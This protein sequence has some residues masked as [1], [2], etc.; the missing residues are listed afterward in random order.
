MR[1]YVI[2]AFTETIF[3]GNPAAV[4]VLD[5]WLPEPL[6][7][8]IAIENNLSET[9]FT[10]REGNV[11]R[12]RWFT[13]GGEVDLCGHATLATAFAIVQ[14]VEP[15][16]ESIIF[17]T[18]S[19]ELRVVK[20]KD[21]YEMDFPSYAM[22]QVAVTDLMENVIGARPLEAWLGRDLVCILDNENSVMDAKPDL[23]RA[24][25][26]DGT[27]LHITARGKECDCVSRS[28]APKLNVPEDPVCGSGHCHIAPLWGAKLNKNALVA[29]QAS[30]RGGTLYCTV[31]GERTVLAGKAVLYATGE[32]HLEQKGAGHEG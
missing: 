32:A 3:G 1:Y 9:A 18:A 5:A 7:Q 21:L 28:F 16:R 13:P 20:N 22:K 17:Q 24:L 11:Y 8:S 15:A 4:F 12:L 26:L 6:M 29:R 30:K 27:L 2:D 31:N 23:S 14:F 10:V 25:E 19:G